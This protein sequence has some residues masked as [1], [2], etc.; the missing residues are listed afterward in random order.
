MLRVKLILLGLLVA[1]VVSAVGSASAS[2][3]CTKSSPTNWVFCNDVGVELGTPATLF[4]GLGGLS[5]WEVVITGVGLRIHCKDVH[6]HG[7]L[8]LLGLGTV[9]FTYLDCKI[10]SPAACKLTAAQE[11]E[12]KTGQSLM[13]KTTG[14]VPGG[15][16]KV[17]LKGEGESKTFMILE[18]LKPAGCSFPAGTYPVT[19]ELII[20]L[21]EPESFKVEH[22]LVVLAEEPSKLKF[23]GNEFF[24]EGNVKIHP[25]SLLAFA[26]L[27]GT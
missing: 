16:P 22:E 26:V 24:Y 1:F 18:T 25:A 11:K 7:K 27:P 12:I 19:G 2:A 14:A 21:P 6:A 17:L 9:G 10:T 3:A 8:E 23:G 4:L 15:P 20:E 13:F 5:L